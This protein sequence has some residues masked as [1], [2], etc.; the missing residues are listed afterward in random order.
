MTHVCPDLR[1][2]L[3]QNP[4]FVFMTVLLCGQDP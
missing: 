2:L 4:P 1:L 3:T